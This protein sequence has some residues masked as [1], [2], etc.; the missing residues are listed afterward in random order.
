MGRCL[1]CWIL[2]AYFMIFFFNF[3][4]TWDPMH[5]VPKGLI[6]LR[7]T[8]CRL[9]QRILVY[10]TLRALVKYLTLAQGAQGPIRMHAGQDHCAGESWLRASS[11][12]TQAVPERKGEE[13]HPEASLLLC[14]HSCLAVSASSSLFSLSSRTY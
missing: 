9:F 1:L 13:V 6:W 5:E 3:N 11:R 2:D 7:S 10:C 14:N 12:D 8:F 4:Y